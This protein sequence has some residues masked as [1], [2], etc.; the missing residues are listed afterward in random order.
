MGWMASFWAVIFYD[1]VWLEPRT[2]WR[3]GKCANQRRLS[4]H[5]HLHISYHGAKLMTG[6]GVT[7][8]GIGGQATVNST[9][10]PIAVM[11]EEKG[12]WTDEIKC[13]LGSSSS[14]LTLWWFTVGCNGWRWLP[15]ETLTPHAQRAIPGSDH[16]QGSK[17]KSSTCYI[18][19]RL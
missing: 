6:T 11:G 12:F 5:Y 3:K 4:W 16:A 9:Q 13:A 10:K 19:A 14:A 15:R 1:S 18:S 8:K 17:G 2:F 7:R